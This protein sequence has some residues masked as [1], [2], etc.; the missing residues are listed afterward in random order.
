MPS[1]SS[2][3]THPYTDPQDNA[4]RN[5]EAKDNVSIV[6]LN[7]MVLMKIIKH[8]T[9]CQPKD[10]SG[11]LV[12]MSSLEKKNGVSDEL[13]FLKKCAEAGSDE[14]PLY[15]TDRLEVTNC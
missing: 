12:G 9:D 15:E 5:T 6:Q 1:S 13:R 11:I 10:V 14:F 8:M 7:G 4:Q 2:S 3:S